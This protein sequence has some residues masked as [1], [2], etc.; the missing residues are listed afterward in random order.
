M[1]SAA[2]L[3]FV[4]TLDQLKAVERRT[5][6]A[7]IARF[8]NSAE[9]SWHAALSALTLAGECAFTVDARHAA[10][11]L[12]MHDVPEIL[13]GDTFLYDTQR[14]TAK[15]SEA[16][17]LTQLLAPLAPGHAQPLQALW[18]EFTAAET[19]EARFA[20]A[21]DR[22][23]P[24]LHNIAHR[25]ETWHAHGVSLAQVKART[26]IVGEVL[27]GLWQRVW[28]QVEAVFAAQATT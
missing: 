28:P 2:L 6:P 13:S 5:R 15:L 10:L 27:P 1:S 11:L 19:A 12:L 4:L 3:D 17:A 26:A 18:D 20:N 24:V 16:E 25:G 23:L 14:D 8:E 21:I 9:H 7:G 22:L